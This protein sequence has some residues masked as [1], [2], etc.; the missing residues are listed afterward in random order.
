MFA[1][2][3][4]PQRTNAHIQN[5]TSGFRLEPAREPAPAISMIMASPRRSRPGSLASV[6]ISAS[7]LLGWDG[8]EEPRLRFCRIFPN[9][10]SEPRATAINQVPPEPRSGGRSHDSREN[11]ASNL[12]FSYLF[13]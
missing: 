4:V 9:R 13:F 12:F 1:A 10:I 5:E 2:P 6:S 7:D 3:K 8:A 11:S